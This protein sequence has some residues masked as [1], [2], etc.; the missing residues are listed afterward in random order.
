MASY[1]GGEEID[2]LEDRSLAGEI[3]LARFVVFNKT[4]SL[5]FLVVDETRDGPLVAPERL[6][7]L[8]PLRSAVER[9]RCV[10][11]REALF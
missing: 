5:I 9:P 6:S 10:G 8:F 7:F 4:T 11:V 3:T 1:A 2:T